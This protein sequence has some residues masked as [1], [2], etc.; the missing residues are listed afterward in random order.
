MTLGNG[1]VEQASWNDRFQLTGLTVGKT[2]LTP[3][4]ALN[5]YHCAGSAVACASGNNGAL[6]TQRIAGGGLD[7]TQTYSYDGVNRLTA[8]GES[9]ATPIQ[10]TYRYTDSTGNHLG[11]RWLDTGTS[12]RSGL[13]ALTLETPQAPGWFFTNNQINGWST[14]SAGN[15][16]SVGSML[17]SFS[18]D[19]ENRQ[20]SATINNVQTLY[21]YDGEG[22][23]VQKVS[24]TLVTT[25]VYESAGRLA[26]S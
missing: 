7:V 2:G 1:M 6:R 12:E 16:T 22:R 3:S 21:R 25:Y 26:K 13:P 8:V 17:R 10:E 24:G 5:Y 18:Y 19:A 23:R 15:V 4:L 20:L 9:G 14:D 11:N